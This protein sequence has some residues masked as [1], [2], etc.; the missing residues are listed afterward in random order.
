MRMKKI[1]SI[2]CLTSMLFETMPVKATISFSNNTELQN[3][4][5]AN[6]EAKS[7]EKAEENSVEISNGQETTEEDTSSEKNNDIEENK[8]ENQEQIEESKEE[9]KIKISGSEKTRIYVGESFDYKEGITATDSK[10]NDI[11]SSLEVKGEVDNSK[12]GTYDLEYFVQATS[13]EIV[14]FKRQ[15]KVIEKNVFNVFIEKLDEKTNS[16]VDEKTTEKVKE[17][18]FSIYI[19]NKTSKFVVDNQSANQIDPSRMN[20]IAFKIRVFDKD[21][22]EKIAIELLGGDTGDSEK[23]NPLK[24]LNYSYGDYIEINPMGL[25]KNNFNIEGPILGDIDIKKED[26]SD[27]VD[28]EDYISNV[29]FKIIEDGIESI[30]NEAP[31][32]SGLEVMDTLLTKREDQL[33]GVKVTD[34]HDNEIPNDKIKISE[35]KD[36]ENNVIG[37]RYEVADSWGRS[38]SAVRELKAKVSEISEVSEEGFKAKSSIAKTLAS[39]IIE[40]HGKEYSDSGS[41]KFKIK[42]DTNTKK[43]LIT[44]RSAR[45]FDNKIQDEYFKFILYDK[46]GSVKKELTVNGSDRADIKAVDELHNTSFEFGDQISLFHYYSSDKLKIKGT[47]KDANFDHVDGIEAQY[48]EDHRFSLEEDGLKYLTNNPPVIVWPKE[49]LEIPR[50]QK[51][52]LLSDIYVI[53]DFDGEIN[54]SKVKVTDYDPNTVGDQ[55]VTYTVTDSW[56]DVATAERTIAITQKNRLTDTSINIMNSAG[57][58]KVFSIKFDNFEKRIFVTDRADKKLD[59]ANADKLAFRIRIFSKAGITKKDIMLNGSDDGLNSVLDELNNFKYSKSDT[60]ELWALNPEKAIKIDGD[61]EKDKQ[62]TEDYSDG[63]NDSNFMTNVRF[64]LGED[65]LIAIYNKAPEIIFEDNLTIKR[66]EVFNPLNFVKEVKDDHDN[67]NKKLVKATYNKDEIDIV[68]EHTITFKVAD[69]WG[70]V[71]SIDKKIQVLPK[72][73]L[74]KTSINLIKEHNGT[75]KEIMTLTFDDVK[76]SLSMKVNEQQN[77]SG[78]A[79]SDVFTITVFESD[80]NVKAK[81]VI[82]ANENL[83]NSSLSEVR[84]VQINYNDAIHISAYNHNKVTI[85]GVVTTNQKNIIDYSN[86]FADDD[87]MQNTRFRVTA[88][89]LKEVYNEA[90][91]IHGVEDTSILKGQ[92]FKPLDK[93]SITDDHDGSIPNTNITV[94]GSIDK[95]KIGP[96]SIKYKVTD[97]WGRTTEIERIVTVNPRTVENFIEF[98]NSNDQLAL[99]IGIDLIKNK[100]TVSDQSSDALNSSNNDTEFFMNIVDRNNNIIHE[101]NAYGNE[102]G[103]IDEISELSKVTVRTGYKIYVW[104]KTP[105]NLSIKGSIKK[106]SNKITEADYS[107]GVDDIDFIENVAFT[108]TED[109]LE[110]VYNDAPVISLP[111]IQNPPNIQNMPSDKLAIYK[112]DDYRAD[113]LKGVTVTDTNET[114]TEADVK[115]RMIITAKKSGENK[116]LELEDIVDLG[117]YEVTYT[118]IDSWG[119]VSSKETRNIRILNSIDR[120]VINLGGHRNGADVRVEVSIGF[121][122]KD[123]KF[124]ITPVESG[125]MTRWY[126]VTLYNKDGQQ[127]ASVHLPQNEPVNSS[128]W[129]VFRNLTF[130]YG[131]YFKFEGDQ[132]FRYTIDGPV[133]DALDTYEKIVTKTDDFRNTRFIITEAG[134]KT[135]LEQEALG[136]YES[137]IQY[138]GSD[139]SKPFIIK[140]NH[141]TKQ[142]SFPATN[143]YYHYDGH[144]SK[145]LRV[146]LYKANENK[147]YSYESAGFDTSVNNDLKNK[148][149][150]G[151]DDGDYLNFEYINIPESYAEKYGG[152]SIRGAINK[153]NED[154]VDDLERKSDVKNVRFYLKSNANEKFIDPV[155]NYGPEFEGAE[156]INIYQSEMAT[157]DPKKG[158][159]VRDDH[160]TTTPTYQVSGPQLNGIGK[161][162]YTYTSTDSWGRTTTLER[163]VYVRPNIF[164]NKIQLYSKNSSTVVGNSSSNPV[165]P[166]FEIEFDNDTGKYN[167][168]RLLDEE[169]NADAGDEVAF[170]ISIY[171]KLGQEKGVITLNGTDIGASEKLEELEEIEY[172]DG[173]YIRLWAEDSRYLV[174]TGDITGDVDSSKEDYSDGIDKAD[175][176]NNVAFKLSYN[177]LETVYNKAPKIEGLKDREVLFGENVNLLD[178]L[179]VSDDKDNLT[180]NDIKTQGTVNKDQIGSYKVTYT[181]SDTWGRSVSKEI[182]IKVVSKIKENNIQVYGKSSSNADEL[183]FTLKFD[184]N[185]NKILVEKAS[186]TTSATTKIDKYFE[187]V[188]RNREA[189]EKVRVTLSSDESTWDNE[190]AKLNSITYSNND[191]ISVYSNE[192]NNVRIKGNIE[193]KNG[194]DFENGFNTTDFEAVRFKI[195]NKGFELIERES[196][197]LNFNGDLTVRRGEETELFSDLKTPVNNPDNLFGIKINVKNCDILKLGEYQATYVVTDSWGQKL[198]KTRK[199][200]V[201]ERNELEKNKIKLKNATD[202]KELVEFYIDTINNKIVPNRTTNSYTGTVTKLLTL[203]LYDETGITKNVITVTSNNLDSL[204][205]VEYDYGD[206]IGISVYDNKNG[207][208]ITGE[209]EDK[210]EDYSNGINNDD[211]ITNVRFN[212][213]EE[214]KAL[215]SV[216]NNAPIIEFTDDLILYKDEKPDFYK[217]VTVKDNDPHDADISEADMDVDTDLDITQIGNYKA[218]YILTDTWGRTTTKERKIVVKSSLGNNKIQYYPPSQNDPA[219]EISIDNANNRFKVTKK[220][221]V[222]RNVINQNSNNSDERVFELKVFSKDGNEK[223]KIT[224]L[225]NSTTDEVNNQLDSFDNSEFEYGDYISVYASDHQNGIKIKGNIDKQSNITEDYSEGIQNTDFMNNVRF[226]IDEDALKAIYNEAPKIT[227]LNPDKEVEVYCGD[228]HNYGYYAIVS[229]DNDIDLGARNVTISDADKEKMKK[230]GTHEI[231]LIVTDSWGRSAEVKRTFKV[232]PG[233]DRNSFNFNG[234]DYEKNENNRRII[235]IGFDSSTMKFKLGERKPGMFNSVYKDNVI[236]RMEFYASDG[237]QKHTPIEFMGRDKGTDNKFDVFNN[238]S[239]TYGDYITINYGQVFRTII[240]GPI[241]N[242]RE[243][244]SDGVNLADDLMNSKLYITEAGLKVEYTSPNILSENENLIEFVGTEGNIPVKLKLNYDTKTMSISGKPGYYD[245]YG[246]S[247]EVLK[248]SHYNANGTLALECTAGNRDNNSNN[249]KAFDNRKFNDGDFLV[250]R[251]R[252][253]KKVR[254]LNKLL[255]EYNADDELKSEDYSDGFDKDYLLH[256]TI[257]YLNK[258]SSKKGMT[259]AKLPTAKIEGAGDIEILQNQPFNRETGVTATDSN[260]TDLTGSMRITGNVDTSKVG[261]N[262]IKYEVTN[263]IGL[264]TT[265]YRNVNVYSEAKITMRNGKT[266]TLEQG[267]IPNTDEGKMAYLKSLVQAHDTD[268]GDLSDKIVVTSTDLNPEQAGTYNVS[269][270]VTNGFR[271]TTTF[272]LRIQVVRTISVDVPTKLPFQIVTNLKDKNADPFVAGMLKLRNNKTSDV[273]VYVESFTKEADSGELEIV[274]PSTFADWSTISEA[275]TMSK[276]A[277]GIFV[278][279]GM[280]DNNQPTRDNP[281]W[282]EDSMQKTVVGILPRATDLS[283]PYEAKLSFKSKH[284]EKF[285]FERVRGKFNLVFRFE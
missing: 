205:E 155:Y 186:G 214:G 123:R 150:S 144:Y 248:I 14:T 239:F 182:T 18:L 33:A 89:G 277:L 241:I 187:I 202:N 38:V 220:Y 25:A 212:I 56:G 110:A 90:P 219:F 171:D 96:Q 258:D 149:N 256:E 66:G 259:I 1:I 284:G 137:T 2:I 165:D 154:Y 175:Y 53:D 99:K 73:N 109:G 128:K 60:I 271:K 168:I 252:Y 139:G 82:K 192:K 126:T 193:K 210:K 58:E 34:D 84:E 240:D 39:N 273:K 31:V 65:V 163:N 30:Y 217:G 283:T 93:V 207:L 223:R 27:G 57:T 253:P 35:E 101:I 274:N 230:I 145:V 114:F 156:D 118:I 13:G 72:N 196:L 10:G 275:E 233:I 237:T 20:E 231:T 51:V 98:K 213:Q 70:R 172:S 209:I 32:I 19:D 36:S 179:N 138:N 7:D 130:E 121:N 9:N 135:E 203:K 26:Y 278:E 266:P 218:T 260:G 184:I 197:R 227:I 94:I 232:K 206:Y 24:E 67:L 28:N 235:E 178:G 21:N 264:T 174:I 263:R 153:A 47:I 159:I 49:K 91:E 211:N 48:L 120:N 265:V 104:A 146:N 6:E 176:M 170:K 188:V 3:D 124:I 234:H 68:G 249:F 112:G 226:R 270:S 238:M 136:Q 134:L 97:S 29:R 115:N 257:F 147:V 282:L 222:T 86:G 166:V 107:D 80:G 245:Y 44:D 208:S 281:L 169:I 100:F 108:V 255:F 71:T 132:V 37:L 55:K 285:N 64:E 279:S 131:D 11:S 194:K 5:I 164:K 46:Y 199:I 8:S 158:V 161:Y 75:N 16:E 76:K 116:E 236:I 262:E 129:D 63:I 151:F 268:E 152:V 125:G 250:I 189:Q 251:S 40:V 243:D 81:S 246:P 23:L 198:E 225:R 50:G 183:K 267:S 45:L 88:D 117:D 272:N 229:D 119:R 224:I 43:I 83:D 62:I 180:T 185:T 79:N 15:V 140:F 122:S 195:T 85:N 133:R 191:T 215:K 103:K 148:L 242:G 190:L 105:K 77:I 162:V 204:T 87:K 52:D 22:K 228:D 216:Y 61:I 106:D 142:V 269:Y 102:T 221:T 173:D 74:E 78:E 113:L 276:M 167:V 200:I 54:K 181:L 42:F 69:K 157:F 92:D 4:N 261:L 141:D 127:R 160:D 244:Y 95:N 17:S 177:G 280:N 143:G 41:L 59:E 201:A 247:G 111:A 254:I 12:V